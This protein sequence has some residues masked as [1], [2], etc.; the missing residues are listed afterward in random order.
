MYHK[1]SCKLQSYC[2]LR[3]RNDLLKHLCE[4]W[5][6][7]LLLLVVGGGYQTFVSVKE[8]LNNDFPVLMFKQPGGSDIASAF[9]KYPSFFFYAPNIL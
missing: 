3:F 9:E 1:V 2:Y 8:S 4:T 7:P 6:I 5:H